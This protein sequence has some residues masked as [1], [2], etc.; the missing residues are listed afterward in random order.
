MSFYPG[1]L[2]RRT[3]VL[4]LP[5]LSVAGSPPAA[6]GTVN[7][8]D[9]ILLLDLALSQQ[10]LQPG[11]PLGLMAR[12][13]CIRDMDADYTLFVH[14]LAPDGTPK[15]QID[16]WPKNGTHP[17][18]R[19]REGEQVSDAY[20]VYVDQDAPPGSYQVEIGWYLLATMQRLPVLDATGNA[21]DDKAL[22]PGLTVSK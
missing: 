20:L 12:W 5:H 13:Q 2:A 7:F 17:T 19:W 16:V 14:L 15:G 1:W 11:A 6:P 9:R 3:T 8:G 4:S 22:F 21:M 18:G 10:T